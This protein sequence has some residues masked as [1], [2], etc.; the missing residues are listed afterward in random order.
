MYH[1]TNTTLHTHHNNNNTTDRNNDMVQLLQH[2]DYIYIYLSI[3]LC[4]YT[5]CLEM[6][7]CPCNST[8]Q[9]RS[10]IY[11]HFI[12]PDPL[13]SFNMIR[14]THTYIYIYVGIYTNTWVWEPSLGTQKFQTN[15]RF[16]NSINTST[17]PD[18]IRSHLAELGRQGVEP[19][20]QKDGE[21]HH[22][23]G[24]PNDT[25]LIEG[26]LGLEFRWF[27]LNNDGEG[28]LHIKLWYMFITNNMQ[29]QLCACFDVCQWSIQTMFLEMA[30]TAGSKP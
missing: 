12:C 17:H 18:R 26:Q 23:E 6:Q 19:H 4:I 21:Q 1:T 30:E 2:A 7:A 5:E 22:L 27:L 11:L 29:T 3:D 16:T 24:G 28:R 13:L 9:I 25:W 20:T 8:A 10:Q 15:A 14:H